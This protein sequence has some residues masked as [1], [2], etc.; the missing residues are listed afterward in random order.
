[1]AQ[2]T[3]DLAMQRRALDGTFR[4]AFGTLDLVCPLCAHKDNKYCT[5]LYCI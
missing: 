2:R 4:G 3:S 1:M 5:V